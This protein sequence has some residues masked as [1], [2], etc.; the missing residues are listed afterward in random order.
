MHGELNVLVSLPSYCNCLILLFALFS[1]AE[2]T[3][4]FN[5]H[6]ENGK[7]KRLFKYKPLK[8][9]GKS[10]Y[11]ILYILIAALDSIYT[12]FNDAQINTDE[13]IHHVKEIAH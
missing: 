10:L 1:N 11:L 2:K 5:W 3:P 8:S 9:S 6:V 7:V 13:I 4:T 12:F